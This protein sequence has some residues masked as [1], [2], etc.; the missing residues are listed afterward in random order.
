MSNFPLVAAVLSS[1]PAGLSN[2]LQGLISSNDTLESTLDNVLRLCCGL[3]HTSDNQYTPEEWAKSV[4]TLHSRISELGETS[5]TFQQPLKRALEY[6]E[7]RSDAK[8]AKTSRE[9]FGV[10]ALTSN[11]NNASPNDTSSDPPIFTFHSISMSSPV[12]KKVDITVHQLTL[13]ITSPGNPLENLHPPI[14]LSILRL[15]FLLPVPGKRMPYLSAVILPE[16]AR[17]SPS[18]GDIQIIFGTDSVLT[19]T[20]YTT[21]HPGPKEA[22]TKGSPSKVLFHSLFAYFPQGENGLRDLYEPSTGDFTSSSGAPSVDAHIGAKDGHLYFFKH[23]IFWGEKKPCV[24][25]PVEAI[26]DMTTRSVTGRSFSLSIDTRFSTVSALSSNARRAA[27]AAAA[28]AIAAQA[29][30]SSKN[31]ATELLMNEED[32]ELEQTEFSLIEGKDQDAVKSWISKHRNEFATNVMILDDSSASRT[33]TATG[34]NSN[35]FVV[36]GTSPNKSGASSAAAASVPFS[37]APLDESDPE[38]GDFKVSD[39]IS[40]ASSWSSSSS[41][42]GSVDEDE[43]GINMGPDDEEGEYESEEL[44]HRGEKGEVGNDGDDDDGD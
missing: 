43:G 29:S 9:G 41:E 37:Q 20:Q 33:A 27:A 14:L 8:K 30:S 3:P 5:L 35:A 17:V 16:R 13:R 23:G 36:A 39:V 28:A 10:S 26:Y 38:D 44:A 4:Q 32:D 2:G 40:T 21:K 24:W 12:R 7:D 25:F 34:E 6:E 22:H 15:A 19:A 31:E 42:R 11:V 18:D 1:A